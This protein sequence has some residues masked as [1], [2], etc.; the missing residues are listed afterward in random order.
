MIRKW[1]GRRA[2]ENICEGII[3][4]QR[5][6]PKSDDPRV[7]ELKNHLYRA[8]IVAEDLQIRPYKGGFYEQGVRQSRHENLGEQ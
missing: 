6:V 2:W 3:K 8:R 1:L 5:E 4:L 7:A